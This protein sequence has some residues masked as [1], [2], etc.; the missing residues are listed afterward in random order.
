MISRILVANRG[1]IARRVF[2]TCREMGIATIAVFS[3]VD[4]D[5]PHVREA[6]EALPLPGSTPAESYLDIE[7][8]LAVAKTAGADAIHPGYGFLSESAGF[9]RGVIES[10]LTWIGPDPESIEIMGSKLESKRLME[11]IGV[12]VLPTVE[13]MGPAPDG[14][15]AAALGIPVLVKASAGGGGKGMRVV[16]DPDEIPAAIAAA[17][18]EAAGA[19][20]DDTVFLERYL[21]APRHI[22]VQ[23]FGD[24]RGNVVSMFERE[25]SIQRRHQ[26]IIEEAPSPALA[27]AARGRLGEA[28]V[29]A[30]KAVD[31]VGAGTVE[32]LVDDDRFYFLEMNTR[33]QVEHPVTEMVTGLDLVR[34][35]IEVADGGEVTEPDAMSGHAIEARLYAE[36]PVADFLPST[37]RVDRFEFYETPGLRVD[38]GVETGSTV[39]IHY[40]PMLAKVIAHAATRETAAALLANALRT[41][42]IHGPVTNR[43]LLVRILE[44]PEFAAGHTDTGFLDRHEPGDLGRSVLGPDDERMAA[45]AAALCD[46]A[47]VA[48]TA[49]VLRSAPLGWRNSPGQPQR[50]VYDGDYGPHQIIYRSTRSGLAI[51]SFDGVDGLVTPDSAELSTGDE[52]IVFSV[53]R[54]GRVRHVDSRL[55]PARLTEIERFPTVET[56]EAA[57]SVHSPMPGKVV[58]VAVAVGDQVSE[59]QVLMVMEAMKME[60]TLR[61]PHDG[62]V[63]EVRYQAGNQVE[64][65]VV[66]VVIDED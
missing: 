58:R 29:A 32:F 54:Y 30:A 46:R 66:L 9:A 65:G 18:R 25:C 48:A 53:A 47:L 42:R 12:P 60:H 20:G 62:V 10:G 24:R 51:E 57:G 39:T 19:F 15:A 37:G 27:V 52:T 22:E 7:A 17:R 49:P 23:V 34:L 45:V 28:A 50:R 3:P 40:D 56:D 55:G 11:R 31:Y 21:P 61:S 4:R 8:I 14:A 41:A 26:K 38:S 2:R 33:L 16:T 44:H 35:Q 63:T 6:D 43:A 36:D 59:G 13:V 1:E 5:E 64:S